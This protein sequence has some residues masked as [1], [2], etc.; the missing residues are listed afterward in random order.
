[1]RYSPPPDRRLSQ[2]VSQGEPLPDCRPVRTWRIPLAGIHPQVRIAH[3]LPGPGALARRIIFDHEFILSLDGEGE[4]F[5]GHG[6][7]CYGPG[8][9]V[10]IPP[11]TPH[12][13]I[14]TGRPGDHI[15][16]HF[17][18]APGLPPQR[19][20]SRRPAH[21]VVVVDGLPSPGFWPQVGADILEHFR[22]VVA[23]QGSA[24]PADR[25]RQIVHMQRLTLAL[26]HL[27][28]SPDGSD[29]VLAQRLQP[30]LDL[31]HHRYDQPLMVTGLARACGLSRS[32]FAD[33]FR[34]WAGCPVAV[35]LRRYRIERVRELLLG[36]DR[37]LADIASACGFADAFHQSKV[38]HRFDGRSP[39]AFRAEA[40]SQGQVQAF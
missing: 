16:V 6:R 19:D 31:I 9:L 40:R 1:M 29:P 3:H 38:F 4:V 8:S 37:P 26:R 22:R 7:H 25:L 15:A 35:Y 12:H 20:P 13:Q 30:A 17:D 32:R 24:D 5:I 21:D 2:Q 28:A 36:D 11:F 23:L 34:D 39:S 33:C 18:W 14:R 10:L 27:V